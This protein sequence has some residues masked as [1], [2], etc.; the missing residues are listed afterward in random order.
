MHENKI[1]KE[2]RPQVITVV[3]II[4]LRHDLYTLTNYDQTI[5]EKYGY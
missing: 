4:S 3:N 5:P 2:I 1:A